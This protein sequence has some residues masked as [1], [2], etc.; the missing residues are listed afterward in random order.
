MRQL[1]KSARICLKLPN[2][3]LPLPA[4]RW[5]M[6]ANG[7]DTEL[8]TLICCFWVQ[9]NTPGYPCLTPFPSV[10]VHARGEAPTCTLKRS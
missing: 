1:P 9:L 8:N 7:A 5:I 2:S 6:A 4:L 3:L 10:R